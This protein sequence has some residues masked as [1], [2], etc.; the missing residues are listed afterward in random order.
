[1]SRIARS[2]SCCC[3]HGDRLG[4]VLGLGD[5]LEV[6]LVVED[7]AQAGAHERVI[8]GDQDADGHGTCSLTLVPS[9]R[10]R[11]DL[12]P[13]ADQ[14]GTL[15]H[16]ADAARG[17]LGRVPAHADAGVVDE[18]L[19][20]AVDGREGDVG[21]FRLRV[22]DDVRQRLLRDAVDDELGIRAELR[23]LRIERAPDDEAGALLDAVAQVAKRRHE[24]ELVEHLRPQ[25]AREPAN[26]LERLLGGVERAR[27]LVGQRGRCRPRE[28]VDLEQ[29]R[30]QPLADLVVQL[31][32]HAP[33]LG[34]LGD[35]RAEA[36]LATLG[37]EPVEH[38]VERRRSTASPRTPGPSA[39]R[40]R[41]GS[42]GSMAFISPASRA[43]GANARRI[44]TRLTVSSTAR[45]PART[46]TRPLAGW[47]I[48]TMPAPS[49][50]A[51]LG[52]NRRQNSGMNGDA[53]RRGRD[54]ISSTGGLTLAA[55]PAASRLAQPATLLPRHALG[56]ARP[57]NAPSA[58]AAA[59]P[60]GGCP[61]DGQPA[62]PTLR[63]A[64][65]VGQ[66]VRSAPI[67]GCSRRLDGPRRRGPLV[68]VHH[69]RPDPQPRCWAPWLPCPRPTLPA[70]PPPKMRP[71]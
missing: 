56:R 32:G 43:S 38:P 71:V 57:T 28:P 2:I 40:R 20:L 59:A 54:S 44:S 65:G 66:D 50:T 55:L 61:T 8:V 22:A 13:G 19:D 26:A 51:A 58:R 16:P 46:T 62:N 47:I 4:A 3:A 17:I 37:L 7:P 27:E 12:Q 31:G 34:L 29:Q 21:L 35:Q 67:A 23:Q 24:P 52:T 14:Q 11:E 69:C 18:Q 39:G 64:V 6:D 9:A 70:S 68:V 48:S 42:S 25:P 45:P 53:D 36:A 15:A 49:S 41:P 10:S 5:D 63:I 30:G 33:A 60:D 1:M